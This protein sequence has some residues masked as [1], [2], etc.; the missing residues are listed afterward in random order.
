MSLEIVEYQTE[1]DIV[2]VD[3]VKALETGLLSTH[4]L[5]RTGNFLS[6]NGNTGCVWR[7]ITRGSE[8]QEERITFFMG[9]AEEFETSL[10]EL[11]ADLVQDIG[12][13]E[14]LS[15]LGRT[16]D[17]AVSYPARTNTLVRCVSLHSIWS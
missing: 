5:A 12:A 17:L 1:L 15:I 6:G 14:L 3:E 9:F 4:K 16:E 10:V 13:V 11:R 7:M 8:I 2:F